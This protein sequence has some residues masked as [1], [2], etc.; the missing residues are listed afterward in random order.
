MYF[1]SVILCWKDCTGKVCIVGSQG[2]MDSELKDRGTAGQ[3]A[4]VS[5]NIWQMVGCD[6]SSQG[7]S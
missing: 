2:K 3:G 5:F 1:V 6:S 7:I 4:L